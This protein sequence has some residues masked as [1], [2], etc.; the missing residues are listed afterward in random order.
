MNF[1][2]TLSR[3][4]E[5]SLSMAFVKSSPSTFAGGRMPT[6]IVK[7]EPAGVCGAGH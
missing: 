3:L 2:V 5:L 4:G 7:I 6:V 1:G